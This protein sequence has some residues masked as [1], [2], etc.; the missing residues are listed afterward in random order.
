MSIP[1]SPEAAINLANIALRQNDVLKA[2]T[3]L[4]HAGSSAEAENA[5][6]ILYMKQ[7]RW[8][9]AEYALRRAEAAGMDVNANRNT[10]QLMQEN[11]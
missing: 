5:R 7:E 6:A 4:E 11:K 2:E 9:D 10:L 3:L 8:L 1:R